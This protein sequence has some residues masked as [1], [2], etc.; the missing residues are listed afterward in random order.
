[1]Y[2]GVTFPLVL[3]TIMMPLNLKDV[4]NYNHLS[5]AQCPVPSVQC[6]VS[7]VAFRVSVCLSVQQLNSLLC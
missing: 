7:S 4:S 2:M 3:Q 6:P 1:M 5:S